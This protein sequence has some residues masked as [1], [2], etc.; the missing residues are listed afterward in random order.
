[1]EHLGHTYKSA[2]EGI[3]NLFSGKQLDDRQKDSLKTLGKQIAKSSLG[4]TINGKVGHGM[5][6]FLGHLGGHVAE[7]IASELATDGIGKATIN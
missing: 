2:G 4:T 6:T 5:A 7:H 1:M 3:S